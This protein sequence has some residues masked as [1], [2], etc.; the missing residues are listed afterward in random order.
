[1]AGPLWRFVYGILDSIQAKWLGQAA[2]L[3]MISRMLAAARELVD[4]NNLSTI[5]A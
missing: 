5:P 2:L 3:T 4:N 1:M